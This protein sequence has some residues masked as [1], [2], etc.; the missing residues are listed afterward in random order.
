MRKTKDELLYQISRVNHEIVTFDPN[1]SFSLSESIKAMSPRWH[2]TVKKNKIIDKTKKRILFFNYS[3]FPYFRWNYKSTITSTLKK[4]LQQQ[5]QIYAY[6]NEKIIFLRENIIDDQLKNCHYLTD[7]EVYE[8]L[9]DESIIDEFQ[10]NEQLTILDYHS[11][12]VLTDEQAGSY[13]WSTSTFLCQIDGKYLNS[14]Y[15]EELL[16][17][18]PTDI[19]F[20]HF[21]PSQSSKIIWLKIIKRSL[22]LTRLHI[23][24]WGDFEFL[25]LANEDIHDLEEA[26]TNID[27]IWLERISISDDFIKNIFLKPNIKEIYLYELDITETFIGSND[28][29]NK[30]PCFSTLE[31]FD[32]FSDP[33]APKKMKIT[34]KGLLSL[35][36]KSPA[37]KHLYIGDS[38]LADEMSLE[39]AQ[40]LPSSALVYLEKLFLKN[41]SISFSVIIYLINRIKK[42]HTLSI[43]YKAVS[44]TIDITT[45]ILKSLKADFSY[46][47]SLILEN[48]RVGEN[49][50]SSLLNQLV[51]LKTLN[52]SRIIGPASSGQ[53][54]T[55]KYLEKFSIIKCPSF[56]DEM[57]FYILSHSKN[58]YEITLIP[59]EPMK[60]YF[61][62][63]INKLP[64]DSLNKLSILFLSNIVFGPG[65]ISHIL[66]L[67]INIKSLRLHCS[68]GSSAV[69]SLDLV[70]LSSKHLTQLN[71]LIITGLSKY[72]FL[73]EVLER[74]N[75]ILNL[76]VS[77]EY[78]IN[79]PLFHDS[80]INLKDISIIGNSSKVY[81]ECYAKNMAIF[82]SYAKNLRS[83]TF[84]SINILDNP[85]NVKLFISKLSSQAFKQLNFLTYYFTWLHEDVLRVIISRAKKTLNIHHNIKPGPDHTLSS[86]LLD[87]LNIEQSFKS[88]ESGSAAVETGSLKQEGQQLASQDDTQTVGCTE[89]NSV[90]KEDSTHDIKQHAKVAED[91]AA[92]ETSS[93]QQEQEGQ[94][95][96][97]QDDT[98][99]VGCTG[100]N[101]LLKE[102]LKHQND[103]DVAKK[104]QTGFVP[105]AVNQGRYTGIKFNT[106][107]SKDP[108]KVNNLLQPLFNAPNLHPAEYRHY[109]IR[110]SDINLSNKEIFY[111]WHNNSITLEKISIK[112]YVD[113]ESLGLET[114]NHFKMGVERNYYEGVM[115][116][117]MGLQPMVTYTDTTQ[118]IG[119]LKPDNPCNF[120][121]DKKQKQYYVESGAES[122]VLHYVI[123]VSKYLLNETHLNPCI[124][125]KINFYKEFTAGKL[126][127]DDTIGLCG[128]SVKEKFKLAKKQKIG[129]CA[130]R[131][132]LFSSDLVE[133]G[134]EH[135]ININ[136]VHMNI[137][138]QNGESYI[139][140]QLGGFSGDLDYSP[141]LT[142]ELKSVIESISITELSDK[143]GYLAHE[144]VVIQ[145]VNDLENILREG[146]NK[147]CFTF[148]R[149]KD[150]ERAAQWFVMEGAKNNVPTYL[151]NHPEQMHCLIDTVIIDDNY[152]GSTLEKPSG[153]FFEFLSLKSARQLIINWDL[154]DST[155]VGLY[156][157]LL[158]GSLQKKDLYQGIPIAEGLKVF[159]L[160]NI[161]REQAYR[162]KDYTTRH[163][164]EREFPYSTQ[165]I[166]KQ[167]EDFDL[168]LSNQ[169]LASLDIKTFEMDLYSSSSW[170]EFLFGKWKLEKSKF[171]FKPTNFYCALRQGFPI[172]LTIMN[173][174]KNCVK[175]SRML[176]LLKYS[177][178]FSYFSTFFKKPHIIVD[179]KECP[180]QLWKERVSVIDCPQ[181]IDD[182][183]YPWVLNKNLMSKF[184]ANEKI[185]S[186][187]QLLSHPGLLEKNK[188]KTMAIFI[189]HE[190]DECDWGL[191][192]DE[193]LKWQVK[194]SIR[195]AEGVVPPD[196]ISKN[197][198][199]RRI[200]QKNL[201]YQE[202]AKPL[203]RVIQSVTPY[204]TLKNKRFLREKEVIIHTVMG[205]KISDIFYKFA[206]DINLKNG[207]FKECKL[208]ISP[209]LNALLKGGRV[210][211]VGTLSAELAEFMATILAVPSPYFYYDDVRHNI[212]GKLLL[213]TDSEIPFALYKKRDD[214]TQQL[215][216]PQILIH[217]GNQLIP[218]KPTY[219]SLKSSKNLLEEFNKNRVKRIYNSGQYSHKVKVIVGTTG[220]GK[221]TFM[222]YLDQTG[223][224]KIYWGLDSLKSFLSQG[225]KDSILFIDEGNL[226]DK[227][228]LD[229]F[230]DINQ[231]EPCIWNDFQCY[232]VAGEIF[233]AMNPA[234]F[235]LREKNCMLINSAEIIKFDRLPLEI[236]FWGSISPA[237]DKTKLN[238]DQK[239][240]V[241]LEWLSLYHSILSKD[242]SK[243]LI[244]ARELE[245]IVCAFSSYIIKNW[246]L[247]KSN[248][249]KIARSIAHLIMQTLVSDSLEDHHQ[250][251]YVE[252]MP[253]PKNPIQRANGDTFVFL[254]E[255]Q[256]AWVLLNLLLSAQEFNTT[257][258]LKLHPIRHFSL[259]G[260]SNL[261]K[262]GF[263]EASL[264]VLGISYQYIYSSTLKKTQLEQLNIAAHKGLAVIHD[265][266]NM[267]TMEREL[268]A[269]LMGEDL[270]GD[271]LHNNFMY[272][273][274]GNPAASFS[275]R[276]ELTPAEKRREIS[277]TM[278]PLSRE[279]RVLL[280]CK[281]DLSL[282]S[283]GRLKGLLGDCLTNKVFLFNKESTDSS[284]AESRREATRI[285][286]EALKRAMS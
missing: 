169:L 235:G 164:D 54:K 268:N 165:I 123:T 210:I 98:Q 129:S 126:N 104:V 18:Y 159:S 186:D 115:T 273:S 58:L 96:A 17:A 141:H 157:T 283:S 49:V 73:D 218:K 264:I 91:G 219:H 67:A 236:L 24:Y 178:T 260:D 255:H 25:S 109:L 39:D 111:D 256:E 6:I 253:L 86:D 246:D 259:M 233:I 145:P 19:D 132:I 222:H 45:T 263:L 83:I 275:G 56:S 247:H 137:E 225:D 156:L 95:S 136:D 12:L 284:I 189:T 274:T 38:V 70:N 11:M 196:V 188:H 117:K 44:D 266:A 239:L 119:I 245:T 280:S 27:S 108:L 9:I 163:D 30:S 41:A 223:D 138:I 206:G 103:A 207:C 170:E 53:L 13:G 43:H 66:Q 147:Q 78:F 195:L 173:P 143:Y 185:D 131:S 112:S 171:V 35:L 68:L 276:R 217:S 271:Y 140:I 199:P 150:T 60:F 48:F 89:L 77:V 124:L 148:T 20:F 76:E 158:D 213:I 201:S 1:G 197:I 205:C 237:L 26:L 261:G 3:L 192:L 61:Q 224:K 242:E 278:K 155:E 105:E 230:M 2:T 135:F 87:R 97:S 5:F 50:L 228:I 102:Y 193:A 184:F 226:V 258:H 15:A 69:F 153:N 47:Q 74:S 133:E 33:Y 267:V 251:S 285:T 134:I 191:L 81:S 168:I 244:S 162:S 220:C 262:S 36:A 55:L 241:G 80:L 127:C 231:K 130:I 82:F 149:N 151:V 92:V 7:E 211:L 202:D 46:I 215:L 172:K 85:H 177:L 286:E 214:T 120:Y 142:S 212:K 14:H 32:I 250:L 88:V 161:K 125:N 176:T 75:N 34:A 182:F 175:F 238:G 181:V 269:Y 101:S 90:L 93:L 243:E 99:T 232:S 272:F 190:L 94:Q 22:S 63:E 257:Y 114:L 240:K 252:L 118:L 229:H 174:P 62:N 42:L 29:F 71:E 65:D 167:L 198:M 265:E 84:S 72:Y 200:L 121:Y 248:I 160:Q 144:N 139:G 180:Q 203:V 152:H 100:F 4:L 254:K 31:R 59:N 116:L 183:K 113:L 57:I 179:F 28:F 51:Q 281:L 110:F 209:V 146:V 8:T 40:Q 208:I 194:L 277:L 79:Q 216:S 154:F 234:D 270:N 52:L 128:L 37:L 187:R 279:S 16:K 106:E 204:I 249:I 227:S 122:C 23:G 221:T 282:E 107:L 166:N 64:D 21:V 10:K